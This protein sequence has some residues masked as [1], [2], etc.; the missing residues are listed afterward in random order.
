MAEDLPDVVFAG[1]ASATGEGHPDAPLGCH[2]TAPE[3]GL[4][5]IP[6]GLSRAETRVVQS[7]LCNMAVAELAHGKAVSYSRRRE[8]YAQ[9]QRY[10]GPLF[11][12]RSIVSGMDRLAAV[13]LIENRVATPGVRG[14]Q[15]TARLCPGVLD[16]LGPAPDDLAFDPFELVRLRSADGELVPYRD[17][18]RTRRWR[19]SL[20]E[21]NEGIAATE[22]RLPVDHA[23]IDGPV[24][25]VDGATLCPARAA[26]YR[27]CRDGWGRGGRFYGGWW[28][29]VPKRKNGTRAFL[30]I[31]GAST[32]EP[33]FPSLHPRLLYLLAEV[34]EPGFDP[35]TVDGFTR[36]QGKVA[37]N[38]LVNA[39]SYGAAVGAMA[40][41]TD[42]GPAL[43]KARAVDLLSALKELHAPV[44]HLFHRDVGAR[45]QAIDAQICERVL[46]DLL[47]RGVVALPVH[48]SFLVQAKDRSVA[49]AAMEKAFADVTRRV[50]GDMPYNVNGLSPFGSTYG[51]GGASPASRSLPALPPRPALAA[52]APASRPT[53]ERP[54]NEQNGARAGKL[55]IAPSVSSPIINNAELVAFG[56]EVAELRAALGLSQEAFARLARVD[57]AGLL[58]TEAG[59]SPWP[60]EER[61]RVR[62]FGASRVAGVTR[63]HAASL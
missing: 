38:V 5:V 58:E 61:E 8:W 4:D 7:I 18:E 31:N 15:S 49:E 44:A 39:R 59:N 47:S 57:Y 12:Y 63:C 9:R 2:W 56:G 41:N 27:V 62:H 10:V 40:H 19:R 55:Q 36:A 26:L 16:A 22:I 3:W 28:Q 11:T 25:R 33:D 50:V 42:A 53:I 43:G 24:L 48:D 52:R 6:S 34:R 60:I 30:T 20:E 32:C 45:L 35:Y 17:T 21:I 54:L 23:E 51:T 37:W 29:G 14:L 46:L 13:G 1:K